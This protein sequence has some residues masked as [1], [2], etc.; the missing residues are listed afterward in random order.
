MIQRD[1]GHL[2]RSALEERNYEKPE[3]SVQFSFRNDMLP[4]TSDEID[5][6][7]QSHPLPISVKDIDCV[8]ASKVE[9]D[10]HRKQRDLIR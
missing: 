6:S 3:N 2:R 4:V 1:G 9:G 10:L 8:K 5:S 7:Y